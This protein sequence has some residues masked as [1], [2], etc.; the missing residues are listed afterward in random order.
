MERERCYWE[1]T[2]F[3]GGVGS[4]FLKM[5]PGSRDVRA[6]LQQGRRR[7]SS[8][9]GCLLLW[10]LGRG[11]GWAREAPPLCSSKLVA[12]RYS[13]EG[14]TY[15]A[16][17]VGVGLCVWGD[18][19]EG[20]G[21]KISFFHWLKCHEILLGSA[22]KPKLQ[23]SKV[24]CLLTLYIDTFLAFWLRGPRGNDTLVTLSTP[25]AQILCSKY[26]Y[27]AKRNKAPWGKEWLQR[28]V[29]ECPKWPWDT[30]LCQ[31]VRKWLMNDGICQKTWEATWK[32]SHWPNWQ[33]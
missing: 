12:C 24:R 18:G 22:L 10:A 20:K 2:H 8:S 19:K 1:Q 6:L 17:G 29:R 4:R 31:K 3:G 30:F 26:L 5:K 25:R 32:G 21:N 15:L 23:N 33:F 28:W 7:C 14:Y 13:F 9:A 27:L 16:E 11:K